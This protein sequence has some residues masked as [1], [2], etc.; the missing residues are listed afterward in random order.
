MSS[1]EQTE[2]IPSQRAELTRYAATKGYKIVREFCDYG[3]S[4]DDTERRAGFLEMR[5]SASSGD[6]DLILCWDQDR[7]GRWDLLDGGHYIRP[8]RLAGVRLET[9]AQGEVDWEGL[10]GQLVYSANQI[11]QSNRQGSVSPGSQ[12]QYDSLTFLFVFI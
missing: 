12:S 7:L 8:F 5:D 11:G 3:I 1:D 9:I 10:T 2:S 6:F 4:G